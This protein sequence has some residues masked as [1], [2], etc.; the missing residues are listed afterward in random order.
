MSNRV[1]IVLGLGYYDES[2]WVDSVHSTREAAEAREEEGL[3]KKTRR[4][5]AA[6]PFPNGSDIL[7]WEVD[8]GRVR[9]GG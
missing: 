1:F 4:A 8:G 2:D 3:T 5:R 7:E 6:G 9:S